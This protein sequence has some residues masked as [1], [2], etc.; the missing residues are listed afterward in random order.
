MNSRKSSNDQASLTRNIRSELSL[1]KPFSRSTFKEQLKSL[2]SLTETEYKNNLAQ[3]LSSYNSKDIGE[4]SLFKSN[5]SFRSSDPGT[6]SSHLTLPT[7]RLPPKYGGSCKDPSPNG[8]NKTTEKTIEF[9]APPKAKPSLRLSPIRSLKNIVIRAEFRSKPGKNRGTTRLYN[10]DRVKI[11]KGIHNVKGQ[12]MFTVID[13]HGSHGHHISQFIKKSFS[14]QIKQTFPAEP[15]PDSIKR[16]IE[17]AL[18]HTTKDLN[19]QQFNL[20]FSGSTFTTIIIAGSTIICGNIG[21]CKAVMAQESDQWHASV[22]TADHS[23]NNPKERQ[24]MISYNARILNSTDM[25][26]FPS[27]IFFTNNENVPGLEITRSIGDKIGKFVGMNSVAEIKAWNV[28]ANDRFLV[29]GTEN[30]WKALSPIEAI[31]IARL[32]WENNSA[33]QS[34]EDLIAQAERKLKES[35]QIVEDLSVVV[36]FLS[37]N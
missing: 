21:T 2:K 36:I 16:T 28:T 11:V 3:L 26:G 23:L 31:C 27:D 34:C 17:K 20:I 29:L 25:Y 12:Y 33:D 14:N 13:G 24:R 9:L 6:K 4:N 8:S 18:E 5:T 35:V 1:P 7:I 15:T 22:L 19:S 32:G 30:L 37:A 10:Q